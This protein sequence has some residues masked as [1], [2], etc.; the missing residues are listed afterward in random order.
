[1]HQG[2]PETVGSPILADK[3]IPF[4]VEFSWHQNTSATPHK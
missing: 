4:S 3:V 2:V 1:M